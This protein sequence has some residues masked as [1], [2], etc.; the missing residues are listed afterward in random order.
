M[1]GVRR[2]TIT[3]QDIGD[4]LGLSRTAVSLAL[5]GHPRISEA[6]KRRVQ[7]A[8]QRLGYQPDHAARALATGSSNLVGVIVPNTADHYYAE[9]FHGIEEAA[10]AAGFQVLLSSGTFDPA[11]EAQRLSEMLRLKVAGVIAAP[12]FMSQTPALLPVFRQIERDKFPLVILNR[13]LSP[14]LFHQV[15]IDNAGG[16]RM[17]VDALV[18]LGHRRVAYISGTPE[19]IPVR[20][21]LAAFRRYAVEKGLDATAELIEISTFSARGGFDACARLWARVKNKP[22][23]IVVFSDAPSLGVLRFLHSQGVPIPG[24]VSVLG[25]DGTDTSEFSAV[26]LTSIAT[27]MFDMGKQAFLLLR[28]AIEQPG[29]P[30]QSVLFPVHLIQRESLGRPPKRRSLPV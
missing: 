2:G 17:A 15:S 7:R 10:E 11:K 24:R 28:R 23:A 6:T 4:R 14:P 26:S 16:I 20:Q 5:R 22:T 3:L 21:R 30:A 19:V 29:G 13:E 27:P 12:A 18:S 1:P 25:F 8:V 9:I